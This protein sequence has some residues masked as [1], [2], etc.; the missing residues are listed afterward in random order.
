MIK[1]GF[2]KGTRPASGENRMR[3]HIVDVIAGDGIGD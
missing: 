2:E 3:S 1:V